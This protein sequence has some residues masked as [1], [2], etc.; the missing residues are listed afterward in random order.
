M[1]ITNQS[2]APTNGAVAGKK[3]FSQIISMPSYQTMLA[4]PKALI[5]LHFLCVR[6]SLSPPTKNALLSTDKGA[7]FVYPVLAFA[8]LQS[9]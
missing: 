1:K 8:K 2:I 4:S 6:I 7:F 5:L 9:C 3:P